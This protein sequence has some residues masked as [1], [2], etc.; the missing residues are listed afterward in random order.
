ISLKL[1]QLSEFLTAF[2][3][4]G[5]VVSPSLLQSYESTSP[6]MEKIRQL[7][8]RLEDR[9]HTL[10]SVRNSNLR[11]FFQTM[12]IMAIISL[13]ITLITI[14]YSFITYKK[15]NKG[16]EDADNKAN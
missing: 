2:Q 15:E 7:V 4:N 16:K 14:F 1:D 6:V 8:N 3:R 13:V 10:M 12:A 5:N 11:G 9:E